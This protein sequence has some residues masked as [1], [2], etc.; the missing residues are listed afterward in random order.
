MILK[1]NLEK[2]IKNLKRKRSQIAAREQAD[3]LSPADITIC[4]YQ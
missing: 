2:N 3:S 4:Q 1:Y